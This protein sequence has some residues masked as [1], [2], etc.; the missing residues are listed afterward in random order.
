MTLPLTPRIR[1][2][3]DETAPALR[4][5]LCAHL[6]W[7][8]ASLSL[9][10]TSVFGA[11][12][13]AGA[14]DSKRVSLRY[15]TLSYREISEFYNEWPIFL[16]NDDFVGATGGWIPIPHAEGPGFRFERT[17]KTKGLGFDTDGDTEID[18]SFSMGLRSPPI[19][20]LRAKDL[21]GR[22]FE[23]SL[24]FRRRNM[25][26]P[27]P[28]L[29]GPFPRVFFAAAGAMVGRMAGK[30]IRL[31][32]G[33]GNGRYDDYGI[34]FL[35]VG[36]SDVATYLSRIVSLRGKLYRLD[37]DPSGRTLRYSSDQG[38]F[39]VLDLTTKWQ[40]PATLETAVVLEQ[41]GQLSFD[42]A[43][44]RGGLRVPVGRYV[45][46]RGRLTRGDGQALVRNGDL[47][48]FVVKAGQTTTIEWGSPFHL[49][50][51]CVEREDQWIVPA[52]QIVIRGPRGEE[53]FDW[54][55]FKN[56]RGIKQTPLGEVRRIRDNR[57]LHQS[58]FPAAKN[59][60][61]ESFLVSKD[62]PPTDP[63]QVRVTYQSPLFGLLE[64]KVQTGGQE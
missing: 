60:L 13:A 15:E 33:N 46:A 39:G 28:R 19:I 63:L 10:S 30:P 16:P 49:E 6:R 32:D 40:G 23:Y 59:S 54:L 20:T 4:R 18:T 9:W 8:V 50:F 47:E 36:E 25:L 26:S 35:S 2:K 38:P 57:V 56:W 1:P 43:A 14:E 12:N 45:L 53:Y 61:C 31:I 29:R 11:A 44:A 5:E 55:L 62:A 37:V 52:Q 24:R 51:P 7:L 21:E 64:G 27:F 58:R 17:D 48:P 42:V 41:R 22:P 3:A 34:D